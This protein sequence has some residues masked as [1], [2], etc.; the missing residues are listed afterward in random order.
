MVVVLVS[1]NKGEV[2][3][4]LEPESISSNGIIALTNFGNT[5][6]DDL[7]TP[8]AFSS[9][10]VDFVDGEFVFEGTNTDWPAGLVVNVSEDGR[11]VSFTYESNQYCVGAVI[12]KGG[13]ASNIY[14]YGN[15]VKDD[16]GLTAPLN[17]SGQPAQLSNLTFCFVECEEPP[18]LVAV[19]IF[20]W[21]YDGV[22][23]SNYSWG[24]SAGNYIFTKGFCVS[25]GV[26]YFPATKTFNLFNGVSGEVVGSASVEEAWPGGVH[27]LVVTVDLNDDLLL[28]RSYVYA[29][30]LAALKSDVAP[31]GCPLY[32][33][34]IWK[35]LTHVNTHI[36]TIPYSEME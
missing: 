5:S 32:E 23:V 7:G 17:A 14:R 36:I 31:D 25:T 27:S 4:R 21:H 22:N 1:C 12:V 28:E 26:N 10:K 30:S 24:S 19:K 35:N 20:Y 16:E 33:N 3:L 6:C 13:N 18:L 29:G 2:E 11:S 9:G 34:W 8:F 15:G